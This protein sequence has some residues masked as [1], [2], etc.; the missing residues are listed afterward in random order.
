MSAADPIRDPQIGVNLIRA[1]LRQW[2]ADRAGLFAAA[3]AF[4]MVFSLAPLLI[5][6][7]VTGSWIFGRDETINH[8]IEQ[9]RITLGDDAMYPIRKLLEVAW[10]PEFTKV[11]GII[12]VVAMFWG[13]TNIFANL[14]H[15]LN[16]IWR[17]P[18]PKKKRFGFFIRTRIMA[19]LTMLL[20]GAILLGSLIVSTIIAAIINQISSFT[21]D[22]IELIPIINFG[23]W[24]LIST[25]TFTMI[26]RV[27][28][29][30]WI[31]WR[32]AIVGATVT[33][34]M[35]TLGKQGVV[36]Y[37]SH[38]FLLTAYGAMGSFIVLFIW[39]YYSA[40][41]FI[42]GVEF[43]HVYALKHGSHVIP[44]WKYDKTTM[45]TGPQ[46]TVSEEAITFTELTLDKITF[47]ETAFEETTLD[48]PTLKEMTLKETTFEETTSDKTTSDKTTSDKTTSD[49]TTSDETTFKKT[50]LE[51]TTLE[52]NT[53]GENTFQETILE[54]DPKK[55]GDKSI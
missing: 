35:F 49:E 51:E 27:I 32:D 15:A 45:M 42:I 24:F 28:P 10:E 46:K 13:A 44:K 9:V 48:E 40:H 8:I 33:A 34:M 4:H 20:L 6:S 36:F 37:L 26:F 43:T 25:F 52:E 22:F 41:V 39:I 18:V 14:K 50:T 54:K 31:S 29:D 5:L 7:L 47:K 16:L 55:R 30:A 19:F 21:P 2:G 11:A 53:P 3:L 23:V 12:G 1:T 38:S 17:V